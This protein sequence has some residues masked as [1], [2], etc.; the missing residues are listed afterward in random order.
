M[1]SSKKLAS[2]PSTG[3]MFKPDVERVSSFSVEIS[4]NCVLCLPVQA[5]LSLRSKLR[6]LEPRDWSL[7]GL[8]CSKGLV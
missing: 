4:N 1:P 6:S 5:V 8:P 2:V 7:Q 3:S